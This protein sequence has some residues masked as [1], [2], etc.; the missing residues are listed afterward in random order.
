MARTKKKAPKVELPDDPRLI[1][2]GRISTTDQR[3]DLQREAL[4]RAGVHED[5]L[6]FDTL[7]GATRDRPGLKHALL[8]AR[9]GDIFVVWKL[10]R[11]ARSLKDLM[12]LL[13]HFR[14]EGVIFRSLTEAIDTSTAIGELLFHLIGA[15]AQFERELV[16]E[17]T[18][19]GMHSRI[20]AGVKMGAPKKLTPSLIKEAKRL[21]RADPEG[22]YEAAAKTLKVSRSAL[23]SA[24]PGG[25]AGLLKRKR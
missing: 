2:Y 13:T 15:I 19:A 14:A 4:I 22:G 21:I 11:L 7:S 3:M 9:R 24:I 5:N 8:D 12:D 16:R 23:T 1:G 20:K 25:V 6:H 10:D 18:K 17:R